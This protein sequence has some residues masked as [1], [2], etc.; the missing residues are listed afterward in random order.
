MGSADRTLGGG[1]EVLGELARCLDAAGV[2]YAVGG[3]VASS[4][5]GE[6][7]STNDIDV[8]V[9]LGDD[10]IPDLAAVL[11]R[12]FELEEAAM[13]RAV[14]R[15]D[16]FQALHL[17]VLFKVDFYV[18]S[19]LRLLDM[20]ALRRRVFL[21]LAGVRIAFTSAEDIV[22]RKLDWIRHSG[23]VL[24][25]QR[26]DVL[27]VLKHQARALDLSYLRSTADA[28]GLRDALES[29]LSDSGLT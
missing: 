2:L 19:P 1:E 27:G 23:G 24:Q 15:K 3:S 5:F 6:L 18:A 8:L 25:Q 22:L 26:R 11:R 17:G 21:T 28:L 7:R 4:Q 9:A 10:R 29:C 12:S 20:P 13:G 14:A 16:M